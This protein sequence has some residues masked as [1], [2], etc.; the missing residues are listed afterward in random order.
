LD[1][2]VRVTELDVVDIEGNV[3]GHSRQLDSIDE[4]YSI[5]ADCSRLEAQ[6]ESRFG[7]LKSNL[8]FDDKD[9]NKFIKDKVNIERA[10]LK[11]YAMS[12]ELAAG[13]HMKEW[14][15]VDLYNAQKLLKSNVRRSDYTEI[16]RESAN[17]LPIGLIR[18]TN[19]TVI[20]IFLS[21]K[22]LRL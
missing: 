8:Q 21:L 7:L 16:C 20:A 6:G 12:V 2:E 13:E 22:H 5:V 9:K 11:G 4:F 1:Q 3:I 15:V 14:E 10:I 19:T 18:S 17:M